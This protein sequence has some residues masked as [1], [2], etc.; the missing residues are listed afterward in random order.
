MRGNTSYAIY[1]SGTCG[2]C[3]GPSNGDLNCNDNNSWG[4][5]NSNSYYGL[6]IPE[7]F[8]VDDWEVF[9]VI[10]KIIP[11]FPIFTINS[12]GEILRM[13]KDLKVFRDKKL[14]EF[15]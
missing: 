10:I 4:A 2:P 15:S 1:C 7:L 8:T 14:K 5:K 12:V 9:K 13:V 3:F 11:I 6:D